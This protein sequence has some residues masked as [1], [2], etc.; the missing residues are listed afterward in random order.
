MAG[1][2]T[3]VTVASEHDALMRALLRASQRRARAIKLRMSF[4][5]HVHGATTD[6][7]IG[8]DG[9]GYRIAAWSQQLERDL[10]TVA[11][12]FVGIPTSVARNIAISLVARWAEWCVGDDEASMTVSTSGRDRVRWIFPVLDFPERPHPLNARLVIADALIGRWI[13]G[14]LPEEVA[15]EELHTALEALL[16]H[17]LEVGP[18]PKWTTLVAGVKRVGRLSGQDGRSLDRFNRLHRNRLKHEGKALAASERAE[19]R[20]ILWDVLAIAERLLWR[21]G[22]PAAADRSWR[23]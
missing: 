6:W 9:N 21:L 1:Y 16:R 22:R 20:D 11:E 18:K 12:G 15:I 7:D 8:I 19:V 5:R 14:D 17:I 4:R 10:P 23:G 3:T 13:V 2:G